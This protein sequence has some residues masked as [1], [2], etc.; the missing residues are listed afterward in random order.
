MVLENSCE[1]FDNSDVP[2]P[3]LL[4]PNSELHKF[5]TN[6][7]MKSDGNGVYS[8]NYTDPNYIE[9][10]YITIS[11]KERLDPEVETLILKVNFK[12]KTA[13]L[14]EADKSID[15]SDDYFFEA[16]LDS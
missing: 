8:I 10:D 5:V 2:S 13:T 12:E 1:E 15:L 3:D 9:G 11:R 14:I 4:V 16:F 6:P 7:N